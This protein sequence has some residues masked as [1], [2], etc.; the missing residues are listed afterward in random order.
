MRENGVEMD[1]PRFGLDGELTGG[2]GKDGAGTKV[3]TRSEAYSAASDAC[4]ELL[5][6]FKAPPDPEQQAEQ[7]ER[8]LAWAGCM[9]E[10]G[11]DIPDPDADGS[12]SSDDFKLDLKGGEYTTANET[13]AEVL[14]E[15]AGKSGG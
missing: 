4:A 3:D 5:T 7:T 14:G 15:P 13:C 9:R 2:L 1:D 8:L 12:F 11:V 6:A 10:Q